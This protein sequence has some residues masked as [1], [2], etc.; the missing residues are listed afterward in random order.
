MIRG[1]SNAA[2]RLW[3]AVLFAQVMASCLRYGS[4]V[5][6]HIMADC[7]SALL[8]LSCIRQHKVQWTLHNA[9]S[10]RNTAELLLVSDENRNAD[11]QPCLLMQCGSAYIK[12]KGNVKIGQHKTLNVYC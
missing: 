12:Q 2:I 4:A 9:R 7:L 3:S 5:Y 6:C 11:V 8:S 1:V 10:L